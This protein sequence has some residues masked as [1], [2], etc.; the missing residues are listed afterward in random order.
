MRSRRS[1]N[2]TT[3]SAR[4]SSDFSA[5]APRYD[6]LRHAEPG[7]RGEVFELLVRAGDLRGRRVLD[8]GCG[9]GTL[10]TWLAENAAG[11]VWGVDASPEM[12]AVAREKVPA[13]VGLKEG[14]AEELP[15]KDGWFERVVMMLVVHHVD[16][17]TAF[18]EIHRV[19]AEDGRLV[20]ATFAPAQ[21]DEYYLGSYFPSIAHID[22]ARF[23]TPE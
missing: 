3:S 2:L 20:I 11:R 21:F 7:L 19:L 15:F 18:D 4:P 9:T 22:H 14:R 13:G 8:V 6:E 17:A 10:A 1:A 12:L 16:R 23:G 5:L